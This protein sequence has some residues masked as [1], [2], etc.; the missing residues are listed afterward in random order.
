L[1]SEIDKVNKLAEKSLPEFIEFVESVRKRSN[2]IP[3][4]VNMKLPKRADQQFKVI[5][6]IL[7]K[8]F[9]K[10]INEDRVKSIISKIDNQLKAGGNTITLIN[11]VH[12]IMDVWTNE[13]TLI[14]QERSKSQTETTCGISDLLRGKIMFNT[15]ED[16]AKAIDACDKICQLKGYEILE[17]DN[18]LSKKETMDVVLKI[19]V[20]EAV[21]EFQLAMKQDESKYHFI[22]AIYEIERSPLGCI[23]G[24]YLYMSKGFNY[25][26][27]ANCKDINERLTSSSKAEDQKTVV[28]AQYIINALE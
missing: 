16:L 26:I 21:C 13:I 1:Y 20:N 12:E 19:Q 18:R 22:H 6:R 8:M 9:K 5:L 28:A 2:G 7:E 25:P 4:G 14:L 17:L 27:L 15:V 10:E 23:F 3:Y 11:I 24:S